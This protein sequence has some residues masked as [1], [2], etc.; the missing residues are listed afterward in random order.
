MTDQYHVYAHFTADTSELFYIG[1]G[2]KAR[3]TTR[4]KR[5]D[6]WNSVVDKHGFESEIILSFDNREDALKEELY[7]QKINKPRACLSYGE[8]TTQIPNEDTRRKISEAAKG[9]TRWLGKK[10]TIES[11]QKISEFRKGKTA[12]IETKLK[13]SKAHKGKTVSEETRKKMSEAQSKSVINCRGK[14]FSSQK[15]AAK[16]FNLKSARGISACISLNQRRKTA[17]KYPDGTP[18]KWSFYEQR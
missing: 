10:H 8:G 1:C 14:V 6:V 13:L 4:F 2:N 11:K 5:N 16:Y 7:L 15:E 18:I 9:H 17:G 3:V 12:S